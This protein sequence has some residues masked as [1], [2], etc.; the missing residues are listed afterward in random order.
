MHIKFCIEDSSG[1]RFLDNLLPKMISDAAITWRVHGYGGVGRLPRNLV[2][3]VDPKKKALLDVLPKLVRGCISTPWID[4][5]VLI[6][7]S[8]SRDPSTFADELKSAVSAFGVTKPVEFFLAVEEMEAWYFGDAQAIFA[9]YPRAKA[10]VVQNYV[11]DS[12]CGTW[13]WLADA[14]EVGGAASL[15]AKG[16]PASGE[17]KHEWAEN[18]SA[19]MNPANN[20]SP[21]FMAFREGLRNL[22]T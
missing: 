2:G 15:K 14:T 8:D 13:E 19:F 12:V 1:K 9:A 7:D 6:V 17:V 20:V 5:L 4:A 21:S 11:Q 10:Q 18:I 22:T 3:A 16:W